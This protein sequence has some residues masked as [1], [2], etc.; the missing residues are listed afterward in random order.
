VRRALQPLADVAQRTGAAVVLCRHLNK[1]SGGE[2]IYRGQGSIGFIGIARSGL[3]VGEHPDHDDVLVLAAAKGNLSEKPDSLAYKIVGATTRE[4]IPTARIEYLGR[5]EVTADRMNAAHDEGE[6]D[7]LGE[8]KRFLRSVLAAGPV[9]S[10][11]VKKEAGEADVA[12]RT[13]ERA[14][15][16]LGVRSYKDSESGRW[17]WELPDPPEETEPRHLSSR[18][19]H[20]GGDG[21]HGGRDPW[22]PTPPALAVMTDSP[23]GIDNDQEG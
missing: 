4:S 23:N 11:R 2:T 17:I 19:S 14:K 21:G 1:S 20:D 18:R 5:T 22:S 15:S 7:R 3:M 6:P 9:W 16:T 8:A 10:G 12:W 13:V